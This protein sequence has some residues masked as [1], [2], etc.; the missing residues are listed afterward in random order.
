MSVDWN[1]VAG[2]DDYL[3]RWRLHGSDQD[4]ND[5]VRPTSSSTGITVSGFGRWVVRVKACNDGGCGPAAAQTVTTTPGQPTNLAVGTGSSALSLAVSWDAVTGADAYKARWRTP[6][7]AFETANLVSATTTSVTITVADYGRWWVQV[8]ACKGTICGPGAI[9]VVD[10]AAPTELNLAPTLDTAGNVRPRTFTA[11]WDALEGATSHTLR[12][13]KVEAQNFADGGRVSA[14]GDDTSA[15]FTVLKDGKYE[16]ELRINRGRSLVALGSNEVQ[17]Y[18]YRP[19]HLSLSYQNYCLTNK[20]TGIEADPVNNGVNVRWTNPGVDSITKYQYLVQQG[21]GFTSHGDGEPLGT[22]T[23]APGTGANTTSYTVTGL[24]NGTTYGVLLRAV[25]GSQTYCFDSLVFVTPSDPTIGPP[26]GFSV[27][28]VAGK[29]REVTVTW[30]NPNDNSLSYVVQIDSKHFPFMWTTVFT[31]SGSAIREGSKLHATIALPYC[32]GTKPDKF[33]MRAQRGEDTGPYSHV[34][35]IRI[36]LIG[37]EAADTLTGT[38]DNDCIFG[39]AGDDTLIGLGGH[40]RI[41]GSD[42][43]DVMRGGE[44]DDRLYG[45]DVR[46]GGAPSNGNDTLD[47]GPGSDRLYGGGGNDTADYSGSNAAVTVDLSRWTVKGGDAEGDSLTSIESVIGS[48][49]ND[50]IT[51]NY[52][53]NVLSGG[54]GDDILSAHDGMVIYHDGN[55]TLRGG[56]GN[57]TLTGGNGNDTLTGSSGDDTLTGGAGNDAFYFQVD[58]GNDDVEDYAL[59][60]TQAASEKIYL[61]MGTSAPFASH[62]GADSGSDHVITVTFNGATQGTITLK[63]ITTGSANFGNLNVI[64]EAV[65]STACQG[66]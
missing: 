20:I 19:G 15:E 60:A 55:D 41:F 56:N 4:L 26:T 27:A 22:W 5:G 24:S 25:A 16:V 17:V 51:G 40:D 65:N 61:C 44:G 62:S 64:A 32:E 18:A 7:G 10:V 23:D 58:F 52:E 42:G 28:R 49:H 63:E 8:W 47:G 14:D 1:D 57:D 6:A 13:R 12:W 33:R 38:S 54:D 2:A 50:A 39:L 31:G 45:S 29:S 21:R 35:R 66:G 43:D 36:G 30:D 34:Y 37:T 53:N 59:G 11:S 46:I 3:V 48:Q 9:Y